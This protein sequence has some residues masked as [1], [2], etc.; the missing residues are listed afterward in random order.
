MKW[1]HG[2]SGEIIASIGEDNKLKI[3][4]EDVAEDENTG[5]RW[6]CAYSQSCAHA[7]PYNSIDFVAVRHE[8]YLAAVTRDGLLSLLE[9]AVP[10]DFS[11]WKELDQF[12]VC[13]QPVERGAEVHFRVHFQHDDAPHHAAV[14][15]GLSELAL[16]LAV[17]A[18]NDV[19]IYRVLPAGYAGAGPYRFQSPAAVLTG[20][21]ALVRD[22]AWSHVTY[23]SADKLAAASADGFVR[24]YEITYPEPAGAANPPAGG[25]ASELGPSRAF[26]RPQSGIGAGLA[27]ASRSAAEPGSL[28]PGQVVHEWKCVAELRH[29]GVWKVTWDA[30]GER[31][32]PD[33]L[34][35]GPLQTPCCRRSDG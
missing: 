7:V 13:G 22:V 25:A 18:V 31:F 9:P 14:A 27:G 30:P 2:I 11:D 35:R 5:R 28:E 10:L 4:Q 1:N 33:G 17:S 15:A 6:K 16:S 3:W 20:S 24:V 23:Q 29:E 12:W 21:R 19:K 34:L 26:A 8:T 32:Q